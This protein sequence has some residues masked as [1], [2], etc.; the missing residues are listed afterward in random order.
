MHMH[1]VERPLGG[2]ELEIVKTYIYIIYTYIRRPL[3]GQQACGI[4]LYLFPLLLS[5][6]GQFQGFPCGSAAAS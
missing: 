6:P 3:W 2:D 5:S 1:T 4:V